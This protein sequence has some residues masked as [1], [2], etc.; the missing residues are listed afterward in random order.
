MIQSPN[1]RH[2]RFSLFHPFPTV[3]GRIRL[4]ITIISSFAV[5]LAACRKT[6][7][8][9][10]APAH[11]F[12]PPA[13]QVVG[14]ADLHSMPVLLITGI[15]D[16]GYPE[17]TVLLALLPILT[18]KV[19]VTRDK[20]Q[21]LAVYS[22]EDEQWQL[23]EADLPRELPSIAYRFA[24]PDLLLKLGLDLEGA[25]ENYFPLAEAPQGAEWA[26]VYSRDGFFMLEVGQ[27]TEPPQIIKVAYRL[28]ERGNALI[29]EQGAQLTVRLK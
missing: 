7:A 5:L 25:E 9:L 13:V 2:S 1:Y 16:F 24:S 27:S 29:I 14:E 4:F 22:S 23:P 3:N 12:R 6:E 8:P 28:E 15:N 21:V 18:G 11:A 26:R 17:D 20:A 19:R 10:P